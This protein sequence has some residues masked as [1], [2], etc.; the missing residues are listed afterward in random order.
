VKIARWTALALAMIAAYAIATAMLAPHLVDFNDTRHHVDFTVG[1]GLPLHVVWQALGGW[2]L[3]LAVWALAAGLAIAGRQ[4]A[5]AIAAT[6]PKA[7][8][9][10][11]VQCLLLAALLAVTVTFSGDVYAYVIYGRL[12]G[13]HGLNPYLLGSPV[14]P[15]GDAVLQQCLLF[16]GN[17]PP[18]DNYGPLWTLL[19]GGVARL[20]APLSLAIQVWTQRVL[21]V[22]AV[23]AATSGILYALRLLPAADRIRRAGMFALHPLVLYEAAVGGHNDMLMIAPAVWA[24]AIADELPLVGGLLLGASIAVKYVSVILIPFLALR[25]GRK[26]ASAGWLVVLIALALPALFFRPFWDGWQTVYSL[27]GHGGVFAMSPQWLAN[28]PFFAS[29]LAQRQ[30][31]WPRA[32][33]FAALAIFLGIA[34]FS[35]VRYVGSRS[36]AN[37]WRTAT[38]FVLALPIIHPWYA[39][40]L[41]PATA[42]RGRWS[43]FAWWLGL[44]A[45]LRYALDG[46]APVEAGAWYTPMLVV[47]T[48]VMLAVPAALCLRDSPAAT[49]AQPGE[50]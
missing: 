20:E 40:W 27:V 31:A 14:P 29:G 44:F 7:W 47:L 5:E 48:V 45:F 12:Y 38:A 4:C 49:P 19:A 17:P 1:I 43:A 2:R 8:L 11:A 18:G 15:Y 36:L 37:I 28:M 26:N 39:L 23:V 34:A 33:Q 41:M 46:I 3:T 35:I 22:L 16:Y 24:F 50:R 42:H 21:A 13:L 10:I 6:R 30:P 32:V 25:A 9:L